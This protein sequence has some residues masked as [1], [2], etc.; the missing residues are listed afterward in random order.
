MR[1]F[2]KLSSNAM[3]VLRGKL[4]KKAAQSRSKYRISAVAFDGRGDF[5]AQ[6]FNG[7]PK[8]GLYGV[9]SGI[10]AEAKLMS[11]YGSI[12]KTILISRIGNGGEWLPIHPCRHCQAMAEK[13]GIKLVAIEECQEKAKQ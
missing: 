11:K 1:N 8:D 12:A 9:G 3:D 10:H 2:P 13:L 7:L 6:S 5:I 4:K